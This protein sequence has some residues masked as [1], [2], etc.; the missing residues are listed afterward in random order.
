MT[1]ADRAMAQAL[2]Y[3]LAQALWSQPGPWPTSADFALL[4]ALR[5]WSDAEHGDVTPPAIATLAGLAGRAVQ[6][7]T[8]S[9]VYVDAATGTET[10]AAERVIFTEGDDIE[11]PNLTVVERR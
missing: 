4:T 7:A 6:D 2:A 8:L 10:V 11:K 3:G 9:V 1:A 5:E